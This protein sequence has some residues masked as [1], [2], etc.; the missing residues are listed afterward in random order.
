[1]SRE[2]NTCVEDVRIMAERLAFLHYAYAKTITEH[3]PQP[4]ADQ[5]IE[6]AIDA[7]GKLAA[8]SVMK[9]LH[10]QGLEPV[11]M[12]Y[13]YGK[14]LPSVG[15]DYE[16]AVMPEDKP[17]GKVS[18]ITRCPLAETWKELGEEG[19]RLGRRYCHVDQAK[20]KAYGKGYRCVHDK[21]TLDGD[22][23]CIIRVELDGPD[24]R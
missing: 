17:Y 8:D 3:L 19:K 4:L 5:L 6:V 16:P 9:T 22:D 11:V 13:K 18:K 23:C 15:W 1:M 7:Y 20:Y 2:Q 14:D 21:N 12:N 10:A 24:D